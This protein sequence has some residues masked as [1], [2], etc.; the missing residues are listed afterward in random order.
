MKQLPPQVDM[1]E[2]DTIGKP[3]K[4]DKSIWQVQKNNRLLGK[5]QNVITAILDAAM[6]R[7]DAAF[8]RAAFERDKAD[9]K[10][11]F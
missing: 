4:F 3:Q 10:L 11:H 9:L 6:L 7:N 8:S 5:R 2:H 1:F